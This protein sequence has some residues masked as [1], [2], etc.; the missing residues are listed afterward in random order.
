MRNNLIKFQIQFHVDFS[1]GWQP[2]TAVTRPHVASL[3]INYRGCVSA[4]A[5]CE[6]SPTE[7]ASAAF[8]KVFWEF[9]CVWAQRNQLRSTLWSKFFSQVCRFCSWHRRFKRQETIWIRSWTI[10]FISLNSFFLFFSKNAFQVW[11]ENPEKTENKQKTKQEPT[12]GKILKMIG[13]TV[14]FTA[15]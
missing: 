4:A 13:V 6:H 11:R 10:S 5:Y 1:L 2:I 12:F 3:D 9:L 14:R 8:C 15:R 7:A